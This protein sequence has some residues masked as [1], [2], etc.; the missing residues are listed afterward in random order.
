[1]KSISGKPTTGSVA[2]DLK[3]LHLSNGVKRKYVVVKLR[4]RIYYELHFMIF[5]YMVVKF[6]TFDTPYIRGFRLF[7]A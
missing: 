5:V 3:S 4:L 2:F 6:V 7:A 1:M